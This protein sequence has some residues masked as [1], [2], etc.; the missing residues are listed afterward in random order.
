MQVTRA[1]EKERRLDGD[2]GIVHV[3]P[4]CGTLKWRDGIHPSPRESQGDYTLFVAV[5]DRL[6]V[7]THGGF[8]K[9]EPFIRMKTPMASS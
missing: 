1:P 9:T 2:N 7:G 8:K 5:D 3:V 6:G 4:V